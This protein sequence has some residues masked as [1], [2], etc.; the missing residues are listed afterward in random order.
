MT[1][2]P[3][4]VGTPEIPG[5]V[6]AGEDVLY[7]SDAPLYGTMEFYREVAGGRLMCRLDSGEFETFEPH[8]ISTPEAVA[9]DAVAGLDQSEV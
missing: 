6:L 2:A 5:S 8:E 7:L 3:I 4:T 1:E 9:K